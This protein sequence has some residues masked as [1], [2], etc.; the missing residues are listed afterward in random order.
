MT[1]AQADLQTHITP[2]NTTNL[3]GNFDMMVFELKRQS[4]K[5]GKLAKIKEAGFKP[6]L[7]EAKVHVPVLHG[8]SRHEEDIETR[9]FSEGP[10][11]KSHLR[12][13]LPG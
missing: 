3:D 7:S 9:S 4:P 2:R 11:R 8:T 5:D 10:R 13:T 12:T 6:N 1:L